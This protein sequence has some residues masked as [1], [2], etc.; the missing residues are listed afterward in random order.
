MT[1][2][3]NKELIAGCTLVRRVIGFAKVGVMIHPAVRA[4]AL[5]L[6]GQLKEQ[7]ALNPQSVHSAGRV[8]EQMR[9]GLLPEENLCRQAMAEIDE[10]LLPMRREQRSAESMLQDAEDEAR[11]VRERQRG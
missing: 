10:F 5:E 11:P 8:L 4:Q 3:N 9:T 7:Q 1:T 6:F 2:M